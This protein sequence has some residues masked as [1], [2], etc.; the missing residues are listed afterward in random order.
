MKLALVQTSCSTH[1]EANLSTTESLIT[2]AAEHGAQVIA[3]QELFH[4]PYF[5]REVDPEHFNLA[6]SVPGPVT[7]RLS[8]LAA[9]HQVV[10]VAPLFERQ[11]A[12]VYFNTSVVID[13]DGSLMGR[14]RK[15][16]IP[17]DPGFYEKYYFT[18]GDSGYQVCNP[19]Y[20]RIGTLICWDQWFPE[21][22]RLTAMKGAD[23]LL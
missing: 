17:D 7:D 14:Y 13:A 5:C 15:M 1:I 22:A 4:T 10:I 9:A 23:L 21:A 19:R 8:R 2:S 16:H 3:L 12:G 18:P 6:E 11:A 20:G